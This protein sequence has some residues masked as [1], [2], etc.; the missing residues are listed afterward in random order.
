MGAS[1]PYIHPQ[2]ACGGRVPDPAPM[3]WRAWVFLGMVAALVLLVY[4]AFLLSAWEN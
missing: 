4:A 2:R 1:V 3:G